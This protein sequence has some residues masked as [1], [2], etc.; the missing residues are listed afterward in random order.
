LSEKEEEIQSRVRSTEPLTEKLSGIEKLLVKLE[1][2]K[3]HFHKKIESYKT[4]LEDTQKTF[5]KK[6]AMLDQ[7][8][9]LETI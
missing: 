2:N 1:H 7:Q 5:D 3:N 6:K 9:N 8:V 4:L